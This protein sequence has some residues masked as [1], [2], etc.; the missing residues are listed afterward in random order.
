MG[1]TVSTTRRKRGIF[2]KIIKL[3]FYLFQAAALLTFV[4]LF[5]I[6]GEVKPKNPEQ[7]LGM[8]LAIGS[9]A[10]ALLVAWLIGS[11]FLGLL[12]MATRGKTVTTTVNRD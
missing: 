12:V 5:T 3:C 11:L 8:I 10:I 2:G 9:S 1:N 6:P 7:E 4:G